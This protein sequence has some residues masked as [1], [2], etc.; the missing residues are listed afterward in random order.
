MIFNG[1]VS[2]FCQQ[3]A[4]FELLTEFDGD[5]R[6]CRRQLDRHNARRKGRKARKG[7]AHAGDSS[8]GEEGEEGAVP[9]NGD[10]FQD[11]LAALLKDSTLRQS[12]E[13]G[14]RGAGC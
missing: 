12:G 7:G 9:G 3:C 8:D 13:S 2:R 14:G 1:Q 5:K 10:G 4:K 6:S 11:A